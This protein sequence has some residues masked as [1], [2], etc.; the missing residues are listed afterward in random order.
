[1]TKRNVK[2]LLILVFVMAL[3]FCNQVPL[4]LNDYKIV[5]YDEINVPIPKYLT[6]NYKDTVW[7]TEGGVDEGGNVYQYYMN[8]DTIYY[9]EKEGEFREPKYPN[10]ENIYVEISKYIYGRDRITKSLLLSYESEKSI[11][12]SCK[13]INQDMSSI[14]FF[15]AKEFHSKYILCQ[16]ENCYLIYY[17][18]FNYGDSLDI[19]FHIRES[20]IIMENVGSVR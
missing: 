15:S 17:H 14:S 8:R 6:Y 2:I 10:V 20:S 13:L 1:M 7:K 11:Y 18:A 4:D 19:D 3:S 5:V 9:G 12:K 16:K